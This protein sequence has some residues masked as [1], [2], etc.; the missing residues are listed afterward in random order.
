MRPN[1]GVLGRQLHKYLTATCELGTLTR[2][3]D[4]TTGQNVDVWTT[5]WSGPCLPRPELRALTQSIVGGQVIDLKRY[6]VLVPVDAPRGPKQVKITASDDPSL[7]GKTLAIEDNPFD[8][9]QVVR[10]MI[11]TYVE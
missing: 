11:C 2:G 3:F 8:D 9:W 6:T 10:T 1:A 7:T 5:A 4:P